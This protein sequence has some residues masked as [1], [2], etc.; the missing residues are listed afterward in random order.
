MRLS[1]L[2]L[3]LVALAAPVAASAKQGSAPEL[4]AAGNY[5]AAEQVLDADLKMFSNDPELL[6]NLAA[7]YQYTGRAAQARAL[8]QT[9]LT[10][11]DVLME[12][13]PDRS[14]WSHAIAQTGMRRLSGVQLSSR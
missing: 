12:F 3:S 7:V 4:I 9:I 11:P 8:Y 2:T 5:Q 10:Q 13:S 14:G 1:L 6:L